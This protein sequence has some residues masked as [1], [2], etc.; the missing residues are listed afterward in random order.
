MTWPMQHPCSPPLPGQCLP[1]PVCVYYPVYVPVPCPPAEP[2]CCDEAC[3]CECDEVLVPQQIDATGDE[4]PA[5]VMVGGHEDVRLSVEYLVEPDA[6]EPKVTVTA[7][8]PGGAE[9]NWSDAGMAAGFHI[10][11]QILTVEPGTKVSLAV[12][13]VTARLRWCEAICC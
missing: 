13:G 5:A 6:S 4:T 10:Q 12:N 8:Q 2:E 7:V 1:Q 9:S 3:E 11:E